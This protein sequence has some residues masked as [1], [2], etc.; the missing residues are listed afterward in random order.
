MSPQHV[1][2]RY[3]QPINHSTIF[4]TFDSDID[5][6]TAKIGILGKSFNE[7][8]TA[9][10][11]AFK[12]VIDNIDNFDENVGFWESLKNNL[13]SK[14]DSNKDW[15]KNSLGEII[16]KENIDSYIKEL[17]L[18]SAKNKIKE[19]FDWQEDINN[20]ETTWNEYFD[21]CKGGN[22][23]IIDLIKNTNDL[24]KLTGEDLVKANQQ[25]REAT[26]AHN[27]ALQQQTLGAKAATVATKALAI[28]GNMI[29]MWAISEVISIVAEKIDDLIHSA[30]NASEAMDE[31]ASESR[32][33]LD[34]LQD[35]ADTIKDLIS[36]YEELANSETY[37]S[38]T[39]SEIKDIQEQITEL[40][41]T[42]ANNLDLVNDKLDEELEKLRKIAFEEA[43]ET[44]D[45]AVANYIN[46]EK[47]KSKNQNKDFLFL[48]I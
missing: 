23:Y 6:W 22:E 29:A 39:H 34:E 40:V 18:E 26:I 42:Q 24:S 13:F 25:A 19:I 7:L 14:N 8:G 28:A 21:T 47:R 15:I 2:N 30:Q 11:N 9:V 10:D 32:S 45:Q 12:A 31:L 20:G 43:S 1:I 4:K 44:L 48:C 37:D 5:K 35:E 17:D 16:S 41:G 46:I 33:R 27:A 3:P 36:K 38:S